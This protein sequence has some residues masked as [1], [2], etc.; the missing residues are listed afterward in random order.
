M[1]GAKVY[2]SM[3]EFEELNK[4]LLQVGQERGVKLGEDNLIEFLSRVSKGEIPA[5]EVDYSSISPAKKAMVQ[6]IVAKLELAAL[7]DK[8]QKNAL[9]ALPKIQAKLVEIEG[10]G[11]DALHVWVNQNAPDTP[12]EVLIY[13]RAMARL[14]HL[15]ANLEG[16]AKSARG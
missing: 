4:T 1:S 3:T 16:V 10:M 6:Q 8:V 5:T 13:D 15:R 11:V 2:M 7:A 12:G 14:S 9:L